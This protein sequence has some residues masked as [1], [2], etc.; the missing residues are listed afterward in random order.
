MPTAR[1]WPA[2]KPPFGGVEEAGEC[3]NDEMLGSLAGLGAGLQDA[4]PNRSGEFNARDESAA[5][6]AA[7][8]ENRFGGARRCPYSCRRGLSLRRRSFSARLT[9]DS[10][11]VFHLTTLFRV[12]GP[13]RVCAC[14]GSLLVSAFADQPIS[15]GAVLF[16]RPAPFCQTT[17][18]ILSTDERPTIQTA[19]PWRHA[20]GSIV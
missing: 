4:V 18:P 2:R 1:W 13:G 19:W 16:C 7:D 10:N 9:T 14:S 3:R 15:A 20:P 11:G 12:C 17:I 6:I 8:D 5:R